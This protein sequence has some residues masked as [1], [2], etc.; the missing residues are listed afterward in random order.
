MTDSRYL[1]P[2]KESVEELKTLNDRNEVYLS[3]SS[4]KEQIIMEDTSSKDQE[5]VSQILPE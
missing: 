2:F 5:N 4:E 3:D 1:S